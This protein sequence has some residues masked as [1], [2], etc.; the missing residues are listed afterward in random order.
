MNIALGGS[1]TSR[2]NQNLREEHG[3]SYGARSRVTLVRGTGSFVASAAVQ[4]EHTGD[5]LRALAK[6]VEDF[7]KTGLTDEEVAKTR[8]I[9]RGE[10]VDMFEPAESA[11]MRLARDAALGLGPDYEA[12]ASVRRDTATKEE[13]AHATRELDP[14]EAYIVV[15]GPRAKLEKQLT[16][17]GVDAFDPRDTEGKLIK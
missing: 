4:T 3:W 10:L 6:D 17:I 8:L 11:A 14:K 9:A 13:L 12:K 15:V 1:F 5:A 2:L 7:A 16:A